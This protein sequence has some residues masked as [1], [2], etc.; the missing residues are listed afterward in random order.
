MLLTELL[1]QRGISKYSLA[2]SSGVPYT[3]LNDICS[4]KTHL[5]K[6]S[7]ETVY[8]LAKDLHF[9]LEELLDPY[10]EKRSSFELFKCNVCHKL[11]RLG[12]IGF[13]IEALKEAIPEFLRFIIV[14]RDIRNVV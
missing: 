7:A 8:R 9:S 11:K 10:L 4:G 1:A 14:E 6:C 3:T 13:I 12:D 5:T 2:K